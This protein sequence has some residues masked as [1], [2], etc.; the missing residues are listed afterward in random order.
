M[1]LSR[2]QIATLRDPFESSL[3]H[4]NMNHESPYDTTPQT[5]LQKHTVEFPIKDTCT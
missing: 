5:N 3:V 4:E 1:A 2:G